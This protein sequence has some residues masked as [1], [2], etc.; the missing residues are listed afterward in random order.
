MFVQDKEDGHWL[1][2]KSS[3]GKAAMIHI[4][5]WIRH[6]PVIAGRAI[7]EWAAEQVVR[8]QAKRAVQSKIEQTIHLLREA[9]LSE[10]D[11]LTEAHKQRYGQLQFENEELRGA[12]LQHR[13]DLHGASTRPCPTCRRSAKALGLEV[14][15]ECAKGEWDRKALETKKES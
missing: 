3:T 10:L 1:C 8:Q 7:L 4:E 5:N 15:N 2:F 14:P 6:M 12:L 11:G 13:E 9:I